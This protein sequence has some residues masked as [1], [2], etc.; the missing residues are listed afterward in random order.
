MALQADWR[1]LIA[2]IFDTFD[3]MSQSGI[4]RLNGND[5][6]IV[7]NPV[8]QTARVGRMALT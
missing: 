7:G 5:P 3:G 2:G 8:D 4:A 6:I 1:P